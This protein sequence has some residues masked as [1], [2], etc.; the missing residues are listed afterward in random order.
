[1]KLIAMANPTAWAEYESRQLVSDLFHQLSQPLT[2]LCCSLEL[3]LL[4]TPT[5][6]Q[7]REIASQALLQAEKAAS[8]ATAIR[9]LFD[10]GQAGDDGEVLELRTALAD[11]VGDLMPLA[12]SAGVQVCYFP[13][14]VCPVWFDVP[15]LRR[16]L[17]HLVAFVIGW[18]SPAAALKIEL[19]APGAEVVL[20]LTVSRESLLTNPHPQI[21]IRSFCNAWDSALHALSLRE[22]V[23]I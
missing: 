18:G 20:A 16:G 11:T 6:A 22:S 7:Y 5:A 2:T 3:A 14:P 1:M 4:Q 10:A 13:G 9:E 8:L 15:R 21:Q 23:E 17:F 19:T 12:E